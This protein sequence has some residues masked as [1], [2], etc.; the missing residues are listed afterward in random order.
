M[1]PPP[2]F[3]P[4]QSISDL[5]TYPQDIQLAIA[6]GAAIGLFIITVIGCVAFY[7][8]K[9]SREVYGAVMG[10]TDSTASVQSGSSM[11]TQEG[12]SQASSMAE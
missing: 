2:E 8:V 3:S 12:E 5:R 1:T 6:I 9:S 11:R 7:W 10:Q 4:Q